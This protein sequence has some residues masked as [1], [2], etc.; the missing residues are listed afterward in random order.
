VAKQELGWTNAETV[1]GSNRASAVTVGIY[2]MIVSS[3]M[4]RSTG[5]LVGSNGLMEGLTSCSKENEFQRRHKL[6]EK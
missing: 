6:F 3:R 2:M 1:H 5:L 4:N